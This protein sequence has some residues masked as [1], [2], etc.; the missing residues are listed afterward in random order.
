MITKIENDE[1]DINYFL[2]TGHLLY[3]YYENKNK[4]INVP[5]SKTKK[6]TKKISS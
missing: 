6:E 1:E 3:E 5:I 4:R 2:N